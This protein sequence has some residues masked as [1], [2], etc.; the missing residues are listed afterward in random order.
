MAFEQQIKQAKQ[1]A[2]HPVFGFQL[3][4]VAAVI[5]LGYF[6]WK[7]YK[8]QSDSATANIQQGKMATSKE[9]GQASVLYSGMIPGIGPINT[10][11]ILSTG[12]LITNFAGVVDAY[13]NL[14]QRD[15]NADLDKYLSSDDLQTFIQEISAANVDQGN[16]DLPTEAQKY[17][18]ILHSVVPVNDAQ[19]NQLMQLANDISINGG[20]N[21]QA[22][23]NN[24]MAVYKQVYGADMSKDLYGF[25]TNYD[26]K[27]ASDHDEDFNNVLTGGN[28][29][30]T[31]P[32]DYRD[33][34]H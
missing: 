12:K 11:L 17:Y 18:N 26:P 14:Y 30:I 6:G 13:K 10:S 7:A 22:T 8:S 16:M 21:P 5:G 19:E 4:E 24:I 33:I 29:V 9:T 3:W 25:W 20:S 28:T 27:Y 1:V 32:S 2:Q 23:F 34:Y 15:L 31:F